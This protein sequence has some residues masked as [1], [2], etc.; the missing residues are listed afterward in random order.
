MTN[1]LKFHG[2]KTT[3]NQV[4]PKRKLNGID[5]RTMCRLFL[6]SLYSICFAAKLSNGACASRYEPSSK[7]NNVFMF[8]FDNF[9]C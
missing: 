7:E 3:V 4:K 1:S 9:F 8:I 5:V 2:Q 6:R